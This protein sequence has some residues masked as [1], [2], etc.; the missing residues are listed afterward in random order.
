MILI[1]DTYHVE[2][3][4]VDTC[5]SQTWHVINEQCFVYWKWKVCSSKH[6]LHMHR[7]YQL[8]PVLQLTFSRAWFWKRKRRHIMWCSF[9]VSERHTHQKS[10]SNKSFIT[11]STVQTIDTEVAGKCWNWICA[12]YSSIFM[13]NIGEITVLLSVHGITTLQ[14]W[15]LWRHNWP[16]IGVHMFTNK[17]H[18]RWHKSLII[19]LIQTKDKIVTFLY[20]IWAHGQAYFQHAW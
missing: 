11:D 4:R 12:K 20:Q 9:N 10:H 14:Q 18:S 6:I 13:S 1:F 17:H 2:P 8:S 3:C 5:Q 15:F 19:S 16:T 7:L